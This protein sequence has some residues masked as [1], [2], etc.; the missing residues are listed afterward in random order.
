MR[1]SIIFSKETPFKK[2][3]SDIIAIL[4]S[5]LPYVRGCTIVAYQNIL[6]L[7]SAMVLFA[8]YVY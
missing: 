2:Y 6:Q 5:I 8:R 3:K 4:S 7:L 1:S